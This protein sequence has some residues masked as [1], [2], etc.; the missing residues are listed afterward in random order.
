MKNDVIIRFTVP[1]LLMAVSFAALAVFFV[2]NFA[3]PAGNQFTASLPRQLVLYGRLAGILCALL[4]LS[5]FLMLNRKRC[6]SDSEAKAKLARWHGVV[7][8]TI[9]GLLAIHVFLIFR[10]RSMLN[11]ESFWASFIDFCGDG[12]WGSFT[13]LGL[14]TVFFLL[15]CCVLMLAGK[16][17]LAVWRKSHFLIYLAVIPIFGHQVF[18]GYDFISNWVFRVF[19]IL[20]FAFVLANV[21]LRRLM[22]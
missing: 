16:L 19:W 2:F 9:L 11:G 6:G 10:G 22:R 14:L 15:T 21:I 7:G 3:G 1:A 13:L 18:C 20:L 5:Q 8:F 12:G 4:F 17:R